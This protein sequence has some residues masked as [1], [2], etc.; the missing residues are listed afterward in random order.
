MMSYEILQEQ[1]Q[2]M[3]GVLQNNNNGHQ[4]SLKNTCEGFHFKWL[5]AEHLQLH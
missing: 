1:E 3:K 4:K 5:Q 2:P